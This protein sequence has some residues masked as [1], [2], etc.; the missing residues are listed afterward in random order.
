MKK[1][2]VCFNLGFG[3]EVEAEDEY[4]AEEILRNMSNEDFSDFI[5]SCVKSGAYSFDDDV[6]VIDMDLI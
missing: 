3:M 2:D 1:F 4:E 6:N 5:T